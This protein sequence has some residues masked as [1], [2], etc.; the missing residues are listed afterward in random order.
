MP[1][2]SEELKA[3]ALA[4]FK[5]S[6]DEDDLAKR[7]Q[8]LPLPNDVKAKLWDMKANLPQDSFDEGTLPSEQ[9]GP[10]TAGFVSQVGSNLAQMG[11]GMYGHGRGEMSLP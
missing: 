7:L 3:A 10:T 5:E 2:L 4:A 8:K 1:Q 11:K 9:V 6:T